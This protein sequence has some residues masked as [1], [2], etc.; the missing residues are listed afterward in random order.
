[1][2]YPQSNPSKELERV[3]QDRV[4]IV[5]ILKR[6]VVVRVGNDNSELLGQSV[7]YH[8]PHES[9]LMNAHINPYSY[10]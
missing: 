3:I 1:M 6:A 5:R 7:V 10:C 2:V 8:L 9:I 4:V